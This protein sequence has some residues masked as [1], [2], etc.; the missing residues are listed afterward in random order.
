MPADL[1]EVLG[2]GR[3]ADADEIKRAY[4]KLARELHPD[5]NPD[6][7]AQERFREVTEQRLHLMPAFT[8]RLAQVPLNLDHPYWVPQADVGS[9]PDWAVS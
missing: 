1:Y 2:V 5:V 7:S 3:K 8:R 9:R 6:E 4:R